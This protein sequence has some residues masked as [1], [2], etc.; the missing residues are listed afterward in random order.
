MSSHNNVSS[1]NMSTCEL[2]P[3]RTYPPR[4]QALYSR[5]IQLAIVRIQKAYDPLHQLV[6]Y[7]NHHLIQLHN[8]EVFGVNFLRDMLYRQ[9]STGVHISLFLDDIDV[10]RR[11]LSL[12]TQLYYL[13]NHLF[14]NK[15]NLTFSLLTTFN[16]LHK[17]N[18]DNSSIKFVMQKM[19]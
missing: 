7:H 4:M 8:G 11:S 16:T 2:C 5:L 15:Y 18:T 17:T 1:F 12:R 13:V 10:L 3:L 9:F 19:E 6:H 14:S